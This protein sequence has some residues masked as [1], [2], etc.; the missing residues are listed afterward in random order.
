MVY[1]ENRNIPEGAATFWEFTFDGVHIMFSVPHLEL[2][3]NGCTKI[4]ED[5]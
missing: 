5:D 4:T 3:S 1:L 2:E